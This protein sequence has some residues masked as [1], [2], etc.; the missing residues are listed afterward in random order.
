MIALGASCVR[1]PQ[2][3]GDGLLERTTGGC[4]RGPAAMSPAEVEA[5]RAPLDDTHRCF[6][7]AVAAMS[8]ATAALADLTVALAPLLRRRGEGGSQ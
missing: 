5:L 3:D 4:G 7:R 6:R 1:C 2:C 8:A